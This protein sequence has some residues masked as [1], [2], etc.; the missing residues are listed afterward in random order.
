MIAR[1]SL[2]GFLKNQ[3]YYEPFIILF[4]LSKGLNFAQIGILIAYRELFIGISEIPS[5]TFADLYGRR[6]SMIVSLTSYIISFIIF[7]NSQYFWQFFIA[8]SF[9]AIGEAFRTG[10][11]KAMIFTW[12]RLQNRIDEKNQVYGF[13][14]SWSKLGSA[15]SV[16]LATFFVILSNNYTSIFYYSI[17]PYLFGLINI[18]TY[19]KELDGNPR[20]ETSLK[21]I[22]KHL[23]SSF[24]ESLKTEKLRRLM[25]ESMGFEGTFKAVKDYIQPIV[26]NFALAIPVF[27]YVD[28]LK[29]SAILIGIVYF[30]LYLGSAVAS[31]NSHKVTNYKKGYENASTFLW[32]FTFWAYLGMIPFLFFKEYLMAIILFIVLYIIQNFWRP[33]LISR[34]EQ[35]ATETKGA[36]ILS[37]ESQAKTLSTMIIAPIL[38]YLI[39]LVRSHNLGGAF[40]P[41]GIIGMLI[42]IS[43]LLTS[44][45]RNNRISNS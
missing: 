6:K 15:F 14:R 43:I 25:I 45:K 28:N 34:L 30:V 16:I 8:L 1:F 37:I 42:S 10:T 7:A 27:L 9:F 3:R 35:F 21:V 12:L 5:G 20:Q 11:H 18:I 22:I 23:V 36:T 17:I 38:G 19:P 24:K 26:K 29:R 4:F 44:R 39:D 32:K 13:T 33:I 40:Y 31:R 2:Y 41:I